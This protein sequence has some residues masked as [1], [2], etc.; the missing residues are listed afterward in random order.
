MGDPIRPFV[1]RD[2]LDLLERVNLK[3]Q[4][5]GEG[6]RD[7][8]STKEIAIY[9][10]ITQDDARRRLKRFQ[11]A[12]IVNSMKEGSALFWSAKQRVVRDALYGDAA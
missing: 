3:A 12:G 4:A 2:I 9:A 10:G 7:W 11:K 1:N 6:T 5:K 8:R